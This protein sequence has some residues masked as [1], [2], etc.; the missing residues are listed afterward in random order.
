M[1]GNTVTLEKGQYVAFDM[2]GE[3]IATRR[4]KMWTLD[5]MADHGP[6]VT[7][8]LREPEEFSDGIGVELCINDGQLRQVGYYSKDE[9][10][11]SLLSEFPSMESG[12]GS[13]VRLALAGAFAELTGGSIEDLYSAQPAPDEDEL[14]CECC[15]EQF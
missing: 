10:V 3:E 7:V 5:A 1:S 15:T 11:R 8:L 2:A 12:R 6:G 9:I 4:T 13:G 14:S